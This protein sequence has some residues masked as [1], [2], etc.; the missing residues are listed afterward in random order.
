[1]LAQA[2]SAQPVGAWLGAGTS[3]SHG[4]DRGGMVL[5]C[6]EGTVDAAGQAPTCWSSSCHPVCPVGPLLPPLL[7]KQWHGDHTAPDS[8]VSK[9]PEPTLAV[10]PEPL[11]PSR[12]DRQ[13][14]PRNPVPPSMG[15]P[16]LGW[17][18]SIAHPSAGRWFQT[19]S[20][21]LATSDCQNSC[22]NYK[23]PSTCVCRAERHLKISKTLTHPVMRHLAEGATT[24][25]NAAA[26]GGF[27]H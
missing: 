8:Q 7:G 12:Q 10:P 25:T 14:E 15:M 23:V 21:S 2:G 3:D 16:S 13:V 24:E 27:S 1:M 17:G 5:R 18:A 19:K 20:S 26:P 22:F 4:G 11:H 9:K 6:T